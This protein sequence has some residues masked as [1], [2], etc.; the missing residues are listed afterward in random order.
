MIPERSDVAK[1]AR[2]VFFEDVNDIDIYIED[3]ATGYSKLFSIIFSRLF[4]GK[5]RVKKVFPIG[6]RNSVIRQ[7]SN[8]SRSDRPSIYI[9]D[10]DLFILAGD[11]VENEPGLFKLPVYCI[12]NLL[13]DHEAIID[14]LDEEEPV[15]ARDQIVEMF[16]YYDWVDKNCEL[17]FQIFIEYSALFKIDPTVKTV[18]FPVRNFVT[19]E[20]GNLSREKVF[21][22]IEDLR[23]HSISIVGGTQYEVVRNEMIS[24]FRDEPSEKLRIVSGKDYLF[25]LLKMRAKSIVKTKMSDIN[26]KQRI[27]KRCGLA[28]VS[29]ISDYV[30]C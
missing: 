3:T 1:S 15:I 30:L 21:K 28:R 7:H 13:C 29:Q 10:G 6:D 24:Q 2:S 16:D 22:R 27:A 12:E 14:V 9:V 19:S 5:Y 26:F 17:L 4:E 25:P 11:I 18:A 20:K 8:H 23:A